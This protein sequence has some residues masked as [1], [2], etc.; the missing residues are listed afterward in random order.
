MVNQS[1]DS[2]L[3]YVYG[4]PKWQLV[5]IWGLGIIGL[6]STLYNNFLPYLLASRGAKFGNPSYS[7]AYRNVR[8]RLLSFMRSLTALQ[9]VILSVLGIPGAFLAGWAVEQRYV[10][11]RGTL[12]I[13]AGK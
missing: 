12:A 4:L 8:A 5:L 11:R 7:I 2:H 3:G 13:S 9:Q 1:A 6:A 10:G